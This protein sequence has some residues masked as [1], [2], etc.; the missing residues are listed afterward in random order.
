MS[1]SSGTETTASNHY[2]SL[3]LESSNTYV[4]QRL[5]IY[6]AKAEPVSS[7]KMKKI[8]ANC[9]P[10]NGVKNRHDFHMDLKDYDSCHRL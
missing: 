7:E 10:I 8:N 9:Q 4:S 1:I 6:S 5:L 2:V 3:C